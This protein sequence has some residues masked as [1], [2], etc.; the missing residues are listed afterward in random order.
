MLPALFPLALSH[1]AFKN[2]VFGFF[3]PGCFY[4]VA[5]DKVAGV[6]LNH[7]VSLKEEMES[8]YC[9][10]GLDVTLVKWNFVFWV[11]MQRLVE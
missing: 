3:F 1:G 7:P 5:D 8:S 9:G 10:L 11:G 6:K 2:R 4:K